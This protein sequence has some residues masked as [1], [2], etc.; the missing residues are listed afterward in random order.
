[1]S[2]PRPRSKSRDE[3]RQRAASRIACA[4]DAAREAARVRTGDAARD[5]AGPGARGGQPRR[6]HQRRRSPCSWWWL[7]PV[8]AVSGAAGVAVGAGHRVGRGCAVVPRHGR[9]GP[10][11]R[12]NRLSG[13]P[14]PGRG[15][16]AHPARPSFTP[17]KEH[18]QSSRKG[19][20]AGRPRRNRVVTCTA[21]A[22]I[23]RAAQHLAQPLAQQADATLAATSGSWSPEARGHAA[24]TAPWARASWRSSPGP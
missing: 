12:V 10:S 7:S 17:A 3:Q 14:V 8:P 18:R 19:M 5:V 13:A 1:M 22:T 2:A 23:L 11:R 9:G 6:D 16:A 24:W 15:R 20:S 4:R 21:T